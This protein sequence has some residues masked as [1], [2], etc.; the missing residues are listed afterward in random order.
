M[1]QGLSK[2]EKI[3]ILVAV[4]V[5]LIYG[6]F[7]FGITPV[8]N[9][10]SEKQLKYEDLSYE[11]KLL[12]EKLKNRYDIRENYT[13]SE[14]N[15]IEIK[16]QYPN[17]MSN[18]EIDRV[19]TGICLQN[20]LNPTLLGISDGTA[21]GKTLGQQASKKE[22]TQKT[23]FFTVVTATMNLRG[24]YASLKGLINTVNEIAYIRI[25]R[26]SFS[27]DREGTGASASNI[28]VFFEVTML[29]NVEDSEE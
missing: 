4:V 29:N 1:K 16:E 25:S 8:Y 23:S 6:A 21:S 5:V 19:L 10:Y 9:K 18:E 27:F 17:I 15:F 28:S 24:D 11:K 26:V 22:E 12:D 3:L 14:E 2:R 13:N 20:K 7:Q